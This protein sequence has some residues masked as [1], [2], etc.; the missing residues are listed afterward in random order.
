MS[1]N[2]LVNHIMDLDQYIYRKHWA[3]S[4]TLSGNVVC[5]DIVPLF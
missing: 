4:G 2:V 5:L 1:M 3:S